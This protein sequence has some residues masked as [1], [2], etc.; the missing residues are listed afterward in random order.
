MFG[1]GEAQTDYMRCE[2]ELNKES[3]RKR[4]HAW[5][6]GRR[7]ESAREFFS[8]QI[9]VSVPPDETKRRAGKQK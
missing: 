8:L 5:R 6:R 7:P 2:E 3:E 1:A 4:K 9:K